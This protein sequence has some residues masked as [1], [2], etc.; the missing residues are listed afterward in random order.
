MLVLA[1]KVGEKLRIGDNIEVVI[2]EIKGDTVRLGL[3]A[4]RGVAIYRQEIYDAIQRE[5]MAA[6]Q[7]P[8]DLTSAKNTISPLKFTPSSTIKYTKG[9][10]RDGQLSGKEAADKNQGGINNEN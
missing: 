8:L 4:P 9:P 10:A 6:S 5:N 3:T 7:T 2:V 1:R